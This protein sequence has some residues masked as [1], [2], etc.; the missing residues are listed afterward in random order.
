MRR[1]L[2]AVSAISLL[3]CGDSSGP[4]VSSAVG[5]WNLVTINGSPLPYTIRVVQPSY[6]LE[7]LSDVFVAIQNGTFTETTTFRETENGNVIETTQPNDGIWSR[8]GNTVTVTGSNGLPSTATISGDRITLSKSG[9]VSVY[10][11]Q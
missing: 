8:N 4:R 2:L 1:L 6:K 11:R 9:F 10:Q 5:T 3:A 7:I